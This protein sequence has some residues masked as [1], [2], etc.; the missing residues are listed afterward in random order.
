MG[1]LMSSRFT[2]RNNNELTNALVD[3]EFIHTE[4]VEKAFR[5]V[6]RGFYFK[7]EEKHKAYRDSAYQMDKIHLSSPGIYAIALESLDLQKGKKFLNI[8]SG[9]GYFST[10]AGL[11]L[12]KFRTMLT[13]F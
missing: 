4:N 3:T 13:L 2:R 6:D 1:Q 7:T 12:G 8:G 5:S 10:V 9:I 11:L